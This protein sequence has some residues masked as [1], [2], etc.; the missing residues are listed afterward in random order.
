MRRPTRER[1]KAQALP[2]GF[3]EYDWALNDGR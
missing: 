3:L 2:V 1:N